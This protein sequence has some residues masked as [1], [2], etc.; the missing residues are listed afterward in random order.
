MNPKIPISYFIITFFISIL[1]LLFGCDQ[2]KIIEEEKFVKIYTD[3]I[4]AE[5]TTSASSK[6]KDDI[7]KAVLSRH[8]ETID[9]YKTT[10]QYYNQNSE[11]WEKFFTK[12]IAYLEAKRRKVV[13]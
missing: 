12:A 11:R 9:D 13:K 7:I 8:N 4:I 1:P 10:I 2:N 6:S 3:I 5:D